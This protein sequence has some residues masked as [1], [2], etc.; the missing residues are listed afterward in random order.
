MLN[1]L[2]DDDPADNMLRFERT[3]LGSEDEDLWKHLAVD[4]ERVL[5]LADEYLNLGSD[6]D[7]LRLL[8]HTYPPVS[9]AEIEPGA[10]PAVLHPMVVYYRAFFRARMGQDATEDLRTAAAGST[11]YV[12]P[13]RWSSVAVLEGALKANP[14]DA[15]ARLLL[16]RLFLNQMEVDEAIAQ[17]QEAR[18]LNTAFP[19]LDRDL[20]QVLTEVKK[21]P[22][23]TRVA[24]EGRSEVQ[25]TS[26]LLCGSHAAANLR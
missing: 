16:G 15:H 6:E 14:S 21:C 18:K 12:F 22:N 10:I 7:A 25:T 17:W 2:Y 5:N 4:G 13:N 11:R 23:A 19:E 9:A 1:R 26:D 24:G 8:S 3:L 20:G